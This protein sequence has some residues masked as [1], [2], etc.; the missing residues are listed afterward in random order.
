VFRTRVRDGEVLEWT[1]GSPPRSPLC[2]WPSSPRFTETP[3]RNARRLSTELT[4]R[5]RVLVVLVAAHAIH[6]PK[7]WMAAADGDALAV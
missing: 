6:L 3:D 7:S 1:A 4:E 5:E 2:I